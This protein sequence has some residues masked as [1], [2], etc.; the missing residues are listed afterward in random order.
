VKDYSKTYAQENQDKEYTYRHTTQTEE[1]IQAY[2]DDPTD[3]WISS[4]GG[5]RSNWICD[6]LDDDYNTR[7]KGYRIKGAHSLRPH[8]VPVQL[9]IFCYVEDVGVA[10]TSSDNHLETM[11]NVYEKLLESTPHE[12]IDY[13]MD[14]YL[15]LIDQQID[16]WTS[17][18]HFPVLILNTDALA[19]EE[20]LDIFTTMFDINSQI[21]KE[22]K[23]K[24]MSNGFKPWARKLGRI[25]KKLKALPDFEIRMP[26]NTFVKNKHILIRK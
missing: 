20:T 4:F 14:T 6:M 3:I 13:N 22:R 9:G 11:W 19:N 25:N 7:C 16:N 15:D 2:I 21:Y 17:N 24:K 10:L 1:L 5:C 26:Y 8:D 12:P 18:P 23:T